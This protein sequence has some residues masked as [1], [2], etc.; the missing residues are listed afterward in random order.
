VRIASF[1]AG[2]KEHLNTLLT[3]PL[4]LWPP[5]KAAEVEDSGQVRDKVRHLPGQRHTAS[6]QAAYNTACLYAALAGAAA[7]RAG[8][9]AAE[10]RAAEAAEAES[11]AKVLEGWVIESLRRAID[12]PQTELDHP[13]TWIRHDPDFSLLRRQAGRGKLFEAFGL[14]VHDQ[15]AQDYPYADHCPLHPRGSSG[16]PTVSQRQ[17]DARP[18]RGGPR[19]R[20]SGRAPGKRWAPVAALRPTGDHL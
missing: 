5:L 10:S 6:W 11:Q 7:A 3:Q 13:S 18:G 2:D 12:N 9:E 4:D 15:E 19:L 1:I 14:F 17:Q 20:E 8:A 16:T